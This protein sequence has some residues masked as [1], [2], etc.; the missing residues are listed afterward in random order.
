[1]AKKIGI[2]GFHRNDMF[3]VHTDYL[4]FVER[5]GTPVIIPPM[6]W[7]DFVKKVNI[8]GLVLPG[9]ADVDP[10]R[11]AKNKL[12]LGILRQWFCYPANPELE[13]F[14]TEILPN[15]IQERFPI[16]GIC[17]GMQT[18]NV[19]LGGTLRNV[20]WHKQSTNKTHM[21]HDI[22]FSSGRKKGVNSFHHQALGRIANS[23]NIIASSTDGIPEIITHN[24]YPIAAVQYHPERFEDDWSLA[25]CKRLFS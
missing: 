1:M 10:A 22:M 9:G 8:D 13:K 5:F 7:L 17:R 4:N 11:Y 19:V 23:F 2:V 3:G 6:S 25:A 15:L 24:H 21:V 12:H 18:L 16:F 14:D 20:D